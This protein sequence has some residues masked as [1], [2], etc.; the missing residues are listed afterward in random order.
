MSGK[1]EHFDNCMPKQV[2]QAKRLLTPALQVKER[3]HHPTLS[4]W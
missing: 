2:R 3:E 1:D 4:V